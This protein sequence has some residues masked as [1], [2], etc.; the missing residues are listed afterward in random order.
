MPSIRGFS[1]KQRS[2]L[3]I[4]GPQAVLR[5]AY[6]PLFCGFARRPGYAAVRT[7]VS[8]SLQGHLFHLHPHYTPPD[9]SFPYDSSDRYVL[10]EGIGPKTPRESGIIHFPIR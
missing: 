10:Q 7:I 1:R 9:A 5:M 4:K 6:P 3:A 8:L 2:H